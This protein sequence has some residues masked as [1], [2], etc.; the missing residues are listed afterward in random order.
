MKTDLSDNLT[1][2]PV[3]REP[4]PPAIPRSQGAVSGAAVIIGT[5]LFTMAAGF[6]SLAIIARVLTPADYGLVAMVITVTS[7]LS[8][9]GDLGLS[10]VTIQRPQITQEQLSALFWANVAFG[11]ALGTVAA[12][13]AP[14]LVW[15]YREPR[16]LLLTLVMAV[17]F[18]LAALGVQH[19]AILQRHMQFLRFGAVQVVEALAGAL[20]GVILALLGYG[21]WA[22]VL[23]SLATA[24][25][26]TTAAWLSVCWLPGAPRR[27]PEL[28]SM[29][30]FGGRLTAHGMIGYLSLN[31][32]K[33]L[34]GRFC[35]PLQLGLYAT[36]YSL[37]G[38]LMGLS[39]YSV[40]Q[41]A[42]PA[43][44]RDQTSSD[45]MRR[46]FRRMLQLTGLLGLPLCIIGVLWGND[47]VL[48][49]LGHRWTGAA[50]ILQA[51]FLGSIPRMIS[52]ST[53]W[54]Y[55][56]TGQPG[57]MLRWEIIQSP[58]MALAYIL[59][60]PYMA[61]GVALGFAISCWV[62]LV[63]GFAYCLRG[64]R[65][66]ASDVVNPLIAPLLCAIAG[67][68]VGYLGQTIIAPDLT[69]GAA[70]FA[71]RMS[72]GGL[73]YWGTAL[74]FVPLLSDALGKAMLSVRKA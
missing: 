51:L 62:L 34:L 42:V 37:L 72:I 38:R 31:F 57:R 4:V 68:L 29:I 74:L 39:A 67:C 18:P 22:L 64:T 28:R 12:L 47:V 6:V 21:Y 32:D 14:V 52:A 30:G 58:L 35:G 45:D 48:A 63:P 10:Y 55:V 50:I 5:R 27:C 3:R 69:A 1:E 7:F 26:S 2:E 43:M 56:A 11:V 16:L 13:L 70:R 44:S 23:Q 20:A 40:G 61:K 41:A 54:I 24:L 73:T 17:N 8:V 66:Q 71:M 59:G 33:L 15:F 9:F 49:V 65:F 60:L 46:T 36:P 53:G 19:L 25:V